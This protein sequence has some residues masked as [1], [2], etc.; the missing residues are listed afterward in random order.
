MADVHNRETRSYNMSRI[1]GKFSQINYRYL[2]SI[3]LSLYGTTPLDQRRIDSCFKSL[4]E[5][6]VWKA[7][8]WKS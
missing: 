3:K 1:K 2:W 7:S 8:S 6:S 5:T 4:F